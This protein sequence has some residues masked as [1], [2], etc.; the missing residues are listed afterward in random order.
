[1]KR[2]IVY[3]IFLLFALNQAF[4]KPIDPI[5]AQVVAQNFWNSLHPDR[6]DRVV[7]IPCDLSQCYAFT[8]L[9]HQGFVLVAKDDLIYPIIG[10]SVR[11]TWAA[12]APA[13][14]AHW[15]KEYENLCKNNPAQ[16]KISEAAW[17]L[18]TAGPV[19]SLISRDL[20]AF[21]STE[22]GSGWPY[23]AKMPYNSRKWHENQVGGMGVAMAQIMRYWTHPVQPKGAVSYKTNGRERFIFYT[24]KPYTWKHLPNSIH[25]RGGRR[26]KGVTTLLQH[27][28]MSL[29]PQLTDSKGNAVIYTE[30]KGIP[31]VEEALVRHFGFNS[32]VMRMSRYRFSHRLWDTIIQ[33][34]INASRPVIL[35]YNDSTTF[36]CDGYKHTALGTYYH[37][38]WGENGI[39]NGN[40]YSI[41]VEDIRNT[42]QAIIHIHPANEPAL[43]DPTITKKAEK[44]APAQLSLID[45]PM[46]EKREKIQTSNWDTPIVITQAE[47]SKYAK[48]NVS[49][50]DEI[51]IYNRRR[52]EMTAMAG[53][54]SIDISMLETGTYILHATFGENVI[55][56]RLNIVD[57]R[58]VSYEE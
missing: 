3:T 47:G 38:N 37:H 41:D 36:F 22:W 31:T 42:L 16:N 57:G 15:M 40:F 52:Q 8:N 6:A 19:D 25:R 46:P 9:K 58:L 54:T 26:A 4:S 17:K 7:E 35:T 13:T 39:G 12:T 5:T 28:S 14:I 21:T 24:K 33:T 20:S 51:V 56:R 23:N 50:I 2:T 49:Q 27:C 32:D 44:E 43:E 1:M 30:S 45:P 55:L 29:E 53:T 10:F 11:Y 18:L 34:E 48:I